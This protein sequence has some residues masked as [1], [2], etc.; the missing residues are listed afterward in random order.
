MTQ[1]TIS[2]TESQTLTA[3]RSFLLA[4]LPTGTEVV[5]GQDNRVPE[6]AGS[7]FIVMTPTLQSR[8]ETNTD[9]YSDGYLVNVNNPS[10]ELTLQ[11]MQLTVQLDIHGTSASDNLNLITSLFR[12]QYGVDAFNASGFDVTPLYMGDP[13]QMP[14]INGE[15]QI[16]TRWTVD[17]VLQCNPIITTA[18]Q[19]ATTLNIGVISVE[20]TYK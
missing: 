16:E 4:V 2:L 9:S 18:Q 12:D 11:P 14:F 1:P 20:A 10:V 3:L 17:T 15:Q 5:K 8:I 13:R 6:P 19:F 7:N